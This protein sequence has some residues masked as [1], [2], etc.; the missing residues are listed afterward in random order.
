MTHPHLPSPSRPAGRLV[1]KCAPLGALVLALAAGLSAQPPPVSSG[2]PPAA[3]APLVVTATRVPTLAE[4]TAAGVTVIT[5]AELELAQ[6]GDALSALKTVPGLNIADGGMPG[7]TAGIFLRGTESRHTVILLDGH[8]LP[9]GLQRYFDVGYFPLGNIGRIEVVRGP[10]GST[11]GGG[12]LGGAINF[13]SQR[14]G[15][16]GISGSLAGEYGTFNTRQAELS[17]SA[18]KNGVYADVSASHLATDNRRPNSE[19]TSASTLD[20]L[21]WQISPAAKIELLTGYLHRDG[22]NPGTGTQTTASDPDESLEQNLW[23]LAPSLTLKTGDAWT[24]TLDF[25]YAHQRSLASRTQFFNDN[26]TTVKTKG[27][28]WQ[29]EFSPSDRMSLQAGVERDWQDADYAPGAGNFA[30]P[31]TRAEREDAIFAGA[32][33]RPLDGLTLLASARRDDYAAF[34]GAATTWRYGASYRVKDS[35][36]VLH[37]SDGTAFAAPEIQNFVDFGFGPLATSL[38]PERSRGQEVGVTQELLGGKL[39]L[40]ATAFQSRTTDLVQFD[41][42]TFTAK[43]IGRARMR[44]VETSAEWRFAA[45][46]VLRMGYTYLEAR[47]EV[48]DQPLTRRPRHTFSAELR[49]EVLPGWTLGA[50][51]RGVADRE[52]TDPVTFIRTQQPG[53]VV[54][55]VFTQYEVSKNLRLKLR[56]ENLLNK[57]YAETAGFPAL[58]LGVYGGAEWRF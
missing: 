57:Q 58:P 19:F 31:F 26:T 18:A 14:G 8:R 9:T 46:G 7:Q 56:V 41:F 20:T 35:G 50:G 30:L 10:L 25:S 37:A 27:L 11:Q 12:A 5:R 45:A 33:A 36:T 24:H 13:I 32:Q 34:Y 48:A 28:T 38:R 47:D 54:A 4:E 15:A 55:R 23:F 16:D 42:L 51:L 6:L 52:D 43:N 40:G 53:Y 39:T 44:G 49:D 2:P 1:K 3:L 21:G 29:T 17:A 22:G